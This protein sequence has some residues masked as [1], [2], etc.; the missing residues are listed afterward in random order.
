MLACATDGHGVFAVFGAAQERSE[1]LVHVLPQGLS[2]GS[3]IGCVLVRVVV[4]V[5]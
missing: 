3:V 5:C 4:L 1:P 2:G